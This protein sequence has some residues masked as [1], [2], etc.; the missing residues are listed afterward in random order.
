MLDDLECSHQIKGFRGGWNCRTGRLRETDIFRAEMFA[1]VSY[2]VGGDVNAKYVASLT[3]K[4]SRAVSGAAAR[5]QHAF[6]SRQPRGKSVASLML[7]E[8]IGVHL[9]GDDALSGE[10]SHSASFYLRGRGG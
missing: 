2:G 8:Q 6:V 5:I 3:G 7:I 10:L 4:L 9:I 1:C